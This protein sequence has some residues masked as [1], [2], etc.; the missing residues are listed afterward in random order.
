MDAQSVI[1]ISAAV[2]ALTQLMKWMNVIPDRYGPMSVL[3]FAAIGI[4]LW[5]WDDRGLPSATKFDYFAGWIA[6]A[7]SAAGVFGFTRA[8]GEAVTRALPPPAGA[9]GDATRKLP[10]VLLLAGALS[11]TACGDDALRRAAEYNA[12]ASTVARAAMDDAIAAHAMGLL[13]TEAVRPVIEGLTLVG[14]GVQDVADLIDTARTLQGEQRDKLVL[15]IVGMLPPLLDRLKQVGVEVPAALTKVSA[16]VATITDLIEQVRAALQQGKVALLRGA[17]DMARA[18]L[19]P[20]TRAGDAWL[21][22]H[23]GGA[24]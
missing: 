11:A 24:R 21:A 2:V 5:A 12:K 6:V 10:L 7:T 19:G 20:P 17:G 14:H 9:G 22:E 16:Y 1:T 23:G 15:R 4:G 13:Q 3:A 18:A 8:T